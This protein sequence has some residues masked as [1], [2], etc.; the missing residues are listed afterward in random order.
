MRSGTP[1]VEIANDRNFISGRRIDR[2][3]YALDSV[4]FCG[5]GA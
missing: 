4:Y 5:M 2:K 3:G 1:L